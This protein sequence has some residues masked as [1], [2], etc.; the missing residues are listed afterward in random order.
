MSGL[1]V[2]VRTHRGAFA[3]DARFDAD[4][5]GTVALLGPNGAGKSTLVSILAGLLRP[6]DGTVAL[7]GEQLDGPGV[8]V[9]PERRPI[10]V[11]FQD[12]RLFPHLSA[13]DNVAYPLRVRGVPRR[14]ARDRAQELLA[15]LA[16]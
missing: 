2:D 10:G 11:V 4:G 15:S 13:R 8:H 12:L 6:G 14:E 3:I 7:D 9:P 5:G 1:L 16:G